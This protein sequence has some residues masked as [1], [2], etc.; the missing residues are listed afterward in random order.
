MTTVSSANSTAILIFSKTPEIGKV[1]TRLQPFLNVRESLELHI[2]LLKDS[3]Q[4]TL[5]TDADPILY[6]TG[7]MELPFSAGIQIRK[8][9]GDDLGQRMSN[10]FEESLHLYNK[11]VIIGIDSP[12]FPLSVFQDTFQ[13]LENQ[14]AVIGPS[15]DGGYYLIALCKTIPEIFQD[16][17]WGTQE[18]LTVT[19]SKLKNRKVSLLERCF[20]VDQPADLERLRIEFT[21]APYLS[22]TGEWLKKFYGSKE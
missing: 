16:V 19:L 12:I 9:K 8:Q 6:L 20:D 7:G 4:K 22:N 10:A 15:E 21:E 18:V 1:K 2:A 5:Q 11:V 17:P 13:R 3:I 14:D